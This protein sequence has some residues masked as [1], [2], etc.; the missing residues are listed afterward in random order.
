MAK[1]TYAD[2]REYMIQAVA[3]RR[4]K[5]RQMAVEYLGGKCCLCNYD[6]CLAALDFHHIDEK[7]KSFGL[8]QSGMTRSW[9]RTKKELNKCVILCANCHRELHAN[10]MQ[11]LVETL[12]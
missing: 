8:S 3:K 10:K 11:L 6:R 7:T 5:I 9:E 4:K 12:R 1:R 2:R